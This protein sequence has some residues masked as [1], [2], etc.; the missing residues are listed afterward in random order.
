MKGLMPLTLSPSCSSLW[1]ASSAE[2]TIG[3]RVDE[4]LP[5]LL[6][7]DLEF[8]AEVFAAKKMTAGTP[9]SSLSFED[10]GKPRACRMA[11][12]S[13]YLA[14]SAR[15]QSLGAIEERRCTVSFVDPRVDDTTFH[16]D[17]RSSTDASEEMAPPSFRY[18]ESVMTV[19]T[20]L[21]STN[22]KPW[23]KRSSPPPDEP[24]ESSWIDGDSDGEEQDDVNVCNTGSLSPRP[25]TPPE[26]DL[27]WGIT[28]LKKIDLRGHWGYNEAAL[29]RKSHSVSGGSPVSSPRT[30]VSR[31]SFDLPARPSSTAGIRRHE[32]REP[33]KQSQVPASFTAPRPISPR[34]EQTPAERTHKTA[35]T[36]EKALKKPLKLHMLAEPPPTS[37]DLATSEVETMLP[38]GMLV[39]PQPCHAV[40]TQPP[41]PRP[42]PRSVQSWLNSSLQ[43]YPRSLQND[44]L[45]RVVP[46]P[47]DAMEPLR[48]SIACFPETMLLSSSLTIETIRTYSK[49][50]RQPSLELVRSPLVR[51][52]T[53]ES[54]PQA[55]RRSLWRKVVPYRRASPGPERRPNH[56]SGE[57]SVDSSHSGSVDAPKP[58]EPLKNVFGGCSDYIC[59]ALYAHIVAYNYMSAQVARNPAPP[60]PPKAGRTYGHR[61]SDS[62]QED[63]PKK[64]ASLLGLTSTGDV[65]TAGLSRPTRRLTTP[66]GTWHREEMNGQTAASA[67]HE[68]MQSDL[69]RCISRLVATAKLMAET[70]DEPML[71]MEAEDSDKL[72]LRSLCEIVRI[73]E[74]AS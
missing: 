58:W 72:F 26:S 52:P 46:L 67:N 6:V 68:N 42:A 10:R 43:P 61:A 12:H 22:W 69:L 29:H 36:A 39:F 40:Y 14:A 34:P 56:S 41:S 19:A 65:A 71:D 9:A 24:C 30:K 23:L 2:E 55:S 73:A 21:A 8:S 66:L 38:T 54:P 48:V 17:S 37:E 35:G 62:Q 3:D 31:T 1:S 70:G 18:R 32:A 59:D 25:P 27:D 33:T 64:A 7:Q 47:P 63:I 4:Y 13:P 57:S 49:K 45:T 20:S 44:D 16:V 15:V 28:G 74:E 5:E 53:P 60:P 11:P 50:V 51:S